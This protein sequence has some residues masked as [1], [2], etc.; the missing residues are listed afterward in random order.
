MP[1]AGAA[2]FLCTAH[3]YGPCR[4]SAFH[5]ALRR[6]ASASPIPGHMQKTRA[7]RGGRFL[8]LSYF[9]PLVWPHNLR[10]ENTRQAFGQS[11]RF[12]L[13]G[14]QIW[15][16]RTRVLVY[17]ALRAGI[18]LRLC[19]CRLSGCLANRVVKGIGPGS[20]H[21][22]APCPPPEKYEKLAFAL[23]A[24]HR[25]ADPPFPHTGRAL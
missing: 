22:R 7:L 1:L 6:T 9:W 19:P 23:C 14:A 12:S 2:A 11:R 3:R 24:L 18:S 10:S 25:C 4:D 16:V 20:F 21:C 17:R 8:F 15:T 5:I 13:Y